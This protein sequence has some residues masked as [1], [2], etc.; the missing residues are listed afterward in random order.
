MLHRQP[1]IQRAVYVLVFAFLVAFAPD[2]A[3]WIGRLIT[4][5]AVGY[6]AVTKNP[7]GIPALV[8]GFALVVLNQILH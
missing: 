8:Y 2:M 4:A 1:Q 3:L 6:I 5:V 7:S